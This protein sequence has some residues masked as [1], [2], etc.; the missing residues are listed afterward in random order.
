GALNGLPVGLALPSLY[1][2]YR[3]PPRLRNALVIG[4]SQSGKS[5]DI[6]SVLAD[7]RSQGALTLA[8]TNFDD[9]ELAHHAVFVLDL[10]AGVQKTAICMRSSMLAW[11]SSLRQPSPRQAD[12]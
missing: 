12:C 4:I 5:P 2:L 1:T 7:A 10:H 9:S 11:K 3:Q 6:V 8:I